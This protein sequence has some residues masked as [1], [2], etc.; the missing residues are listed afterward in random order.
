MRG[1]KVEYMP[2]G[3]PEQTLASLRAQRLESLCVMR[4]HWVTFLVVAGLCIFATWSVTWLSLSRQAAL[5]RSQNALLQ[6]RMNAFASTPPS[7]WRHLS[8]RARGLVLAGLEHPDNNFKALIVYATADSESRQYAAQFVDAARLVG[9]DVR[10]REAALTVSS[11]TGL[12]VGTT[13][14]TPSEQAERLKEIL[15]SAGLDVRYSSW[16]RPPGDDVPVDF[17]LFVGPKPW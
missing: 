17:A 15:S 12:V 10:P 3:K 16:A 2:E 9:I 13:T 4:R 14:A 11:D 7:Q 6:D 1:D 5:L 8:D